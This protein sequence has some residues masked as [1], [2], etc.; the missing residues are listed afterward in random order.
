MSNKL[1]WARRGPKPKEAIV[2]DSTPEWEIHEELLPPGS[3]WEDVRRLIR[4]RQNAGWTHFYAA[5]DAIYLP[6]GA[7]PPE[8]LFGKLVFWRRIRA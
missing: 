5:S 8:R 1:E 4:E 2:S 3:T 7:P 6:E